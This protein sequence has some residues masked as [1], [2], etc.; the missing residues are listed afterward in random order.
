MKLSELRQQIRQKEHQGEHESVAQLLHGNPLST[1]ARERV[2]KASQQLV[3][4][5]RN[6]KSSGGTLDAFLLEFGLANDEGV[7][8]M[9]LAEALL[10]I[11][12][13]LT[14]D[15][16]IAEKIQG[17][18]WSDHRGLSESL[19]VNASTWGLMLT[20]HMVSLDSNITTETDTWLKRL[21]ARMG[22]PVIR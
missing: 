17:G 22:E 18:K 15:R 12:D 13:D 20:G 7:A 19:F 4:E 14:A 9:C 3:T 11:P 16:L 5:C 8:L 6:E 2:L 1:E 21:T 10:R